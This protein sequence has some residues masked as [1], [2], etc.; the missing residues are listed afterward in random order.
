MDIII[1]K[2]IL[3]I[4]THKPDKVANS[5]VPTFICDSEEERDK[6]AFNLS[7]LTDSVIHDLENGVLVAVKH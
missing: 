2:V 7:K 4:V 5:G 3:A 1:T 6:V